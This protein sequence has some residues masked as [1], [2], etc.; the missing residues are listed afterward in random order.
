MSSSFRSLKPVLSILNRRGT[1]RGNPRQAPI[2]PRHLFRPWRFERHLITQQIGPNL[3]GP[4]N[5][6]DGPESKAPQKEKE[7][8][9]F[10]W[11]QT[12]FKMAE[13]ALTT[14]ASVAIL[15]FVQQQASALAERS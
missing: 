6:A 5:E 13:A 4:P 8:E 15:G 1:Y 2:T 7:S 3:P 9:K 10:D 12:L 14:L 11:G